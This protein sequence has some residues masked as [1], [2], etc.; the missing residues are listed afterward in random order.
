MIPSRYCMYVHTV[1]TYVQYVY[2]RYFREGDFSKYIR[3]YEQ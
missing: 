3:V 2:I 1:G